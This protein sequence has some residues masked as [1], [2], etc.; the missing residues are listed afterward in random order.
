M[1]VLI[2]KSLKPT[3]FVVHQPLWLL[4]WEQLADWS[5]ESV[6]QQTYSYFRVSPLTK[7]SI[8]KSAPLD[9]QVNL[10]GG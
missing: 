3:Q 5:S 2:P 1:Q 9:T 10:S 4:G 8:W 7:G 6:F